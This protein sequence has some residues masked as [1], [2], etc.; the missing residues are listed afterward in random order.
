MA[1]QNL[2]LGADGL[3]EG[4]D[5]PGEA[6]TTVVITQVPFCTP[7]TTPK[8]GISSPAA[9]T[10]TSNLP[11]A[12]RARVGTNTGIGSEALVADGTEAQKQRWLPRMARG[13]L[14]GCFGLTEAHGGSDPASMKTRA[15][16]DGGDWRISGSKM[17][18][19][20]GPVADLA[21]VWAPSP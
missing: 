5:L 4:L 7:S 20:S 3:G 21:I 12:L 18:I 13:E 14:I 8:A 19:T 11:V 9:W 15:V 10:E 2:G 16:R 17:W 6:C 1:F